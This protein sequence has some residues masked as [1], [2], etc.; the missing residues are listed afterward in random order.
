MDDQPT[1]STSRLKNPLVLM[2]IIGLLVRLV[3][4]PL[5]TYDFDM[6]HWAL[7]VSNINSGHGLY[8]LDG[9]YYT[10]VWGY[11][12]GAISF[13][14]GVLTEGLLG[15]RSTDMLPIE[16]LSHRFHIATITS[17]SFNVIMKIPMVICD[18]AVGYLI[19]W[20]VKD[21]TGDKKKA[22][23]GF[24]L[25]FFC[26]IVLYMSAVQGMF[27]TISA[28]L[29]LLTTVAVYKNKYFV[30]GMM[31]ATAVLLKFF[32]AFCIFVLLS[33]IIVKHRDDGLA[34][35]KIL[36]TIAGAVL[37]SVVLMLPLIINGQMADALTFITGRT[38]SVGML[39]TA[40]NGAIA[41]AAS[42]F[43]GYKMY[44]TP[45]ENAD[46]HM[47]IYIFF[48]ITASTLISMTPQYVIVMLPFL[49]LFTLSEDRGYLK[50][51]VIIGVAAFFGAFLLNNY[52]LFC[53]LAV[54]TDLIS[55]GWVIDG[56][57][58]LESDF[59][60]GP[61]ILSLT[62]MANSAQ[63]IGLLLVFIFCFADSINKRFP[64]LGK[65]ILRIK[66]TEAHVDET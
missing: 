64:W 61:L 51:W 57:H 32:P 49:I 27:D 40:F 16:E 63:Y 62:G 36:E 56:M 20:L 7:I 13:M 17:I 8:E 29:L 53:S 33:Y 23:T 45:A 38:G 44:K 37:I 47:F 4:M 52:S 60:G 42:L 55:P 28:L 21:R 3:L 39:F 41:V 43:F 22:V 34:K 12:M 19:Y 58:L 14:Q 24:G 50:C 10:P 54:H 18:L 15:I 5:L 48:T 11:F 9:Y 46:R 31:F 6:Y 2:V 25:W 35:M 30:C 1:P 65:I 59:F 26:P 66:G